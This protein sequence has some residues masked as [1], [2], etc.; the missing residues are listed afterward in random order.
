MGDGLHMMLGAIVVGVGLQGQQ[1]SVLPILLA[2]ML[3]MKG[4]E[5][6]LGVRLGLDHDVGLA[7]C[8]AEFIGFMADGVAIHQDGEVQIGGRRRERSRRLGAAAA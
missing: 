6:H 4:Q 7:L 8:L 3:V 1:L 5:Q 2:L